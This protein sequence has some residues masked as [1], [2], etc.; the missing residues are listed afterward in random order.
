[1]VIKEFRLFALLEVP[2]IQISLTR[3]IEKRAYC[4][5][6]IRC[7]LFLPQPK[8]SDV[9]LRLCCS[10]CSSKSNMLYLN[11]CWQDCEFLV[12]P[13]LFRPTFQHCKLMDCVVQIPIRYVQHIHAQKGENSG[14]LSSSTFKINLLS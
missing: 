9:F 5:S 10:V 4:I 12:S 14:L 8:N 6:S 1:M 7:L 3:H 13:E 11:N 2:Q